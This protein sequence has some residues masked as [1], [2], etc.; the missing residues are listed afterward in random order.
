MIR[1]SVLLLL[2]ISAPTA[3]AEEPPS[4]DYVEP[5]LTDDDR[6]HWAFIPPQETDPP[7]AGHPDRRNEIDDFVAAALQD[8]EL[9]LR[10]AADRSTLIR[11]LCFNLTGLPPTQDQRDRFLNDRDP[12]A[13]EK[14]TDRLLS[15]KAYGE[16]WGQHWL[17]LARFAETDGF[18]H[19]KVRP[20]A[21]KYRDWVIQALNDDMPY[22][23]FIR[24]QIAGDELYPGDESSA[25]A[26][27][28]CLCG[29]DMPDINLIDERRHTLLNEMTSTI[30]EAILG[31]QL[32]CAQCHDHKYDPVSQADFYRMRAVFEPAVQLQKNKSVSVLKEKRPFDRPQHVM[33][34]GD[35]RRPGPEISPGV[36]RVAAAPEF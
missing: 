20:E 21:W 10:P 31:L 34:R 6:S 35:F 22:D 26:T 4:S 3:C 36:L 7:A 30:G 12:Q 17:D 23:E 18:E 27:M 25:T 8:S 29:P 33:L 5:T 24:R 9:T 1:L 32:G 19:D 16:R 15:S 14:L 13:W 28:F 11:R 2:F